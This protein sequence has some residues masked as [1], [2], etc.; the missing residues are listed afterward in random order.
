MLLEFDNSS[1]LTS[2]SV[3]FKKKEKARDLNTVYNLGLLSHEQGR[4]NK[5]E[6][7]L[8]KALEGREKALGKEHSNTLSSVNSLGLVLES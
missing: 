8:R 1:I 3:K 4:L 2:S 5:V 6:K 7:M